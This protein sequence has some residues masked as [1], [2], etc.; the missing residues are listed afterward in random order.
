MLKLVS[1]KYIIASVIAQF[2]PDKLKL[3]YKKLNLA[4]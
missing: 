2:T 3:A 4:T 1:V